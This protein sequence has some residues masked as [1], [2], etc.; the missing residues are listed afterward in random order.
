[1]IDLED[2]YFGHTHVKNLKA[3][4]IHKAEMIEIFFQSF[5]NGNLIE[6]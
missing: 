1:M 5:D 4:F 6:A 2:G 3:L